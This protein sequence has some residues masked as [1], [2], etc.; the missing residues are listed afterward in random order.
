MNCILTHHIKY[1]SMQ[2]AFYIKN[3]FQT[4][5]CF[6]LL[7]IKSHFVFFIIHFFK[8]CI[9]TLCHCFFKAFMILY[10]IPYCIHL[11]SFQ[12][13]CNKSRHKNNKNIFCYFPYFLCCLYS[14]YFFHIHIKKNNMILIK[15][16]SQI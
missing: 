7:K 5:C 1:Q 11:V 9:H 14:I 8:D 16:F 6:P 15:F 2:I 3:I 10:E 13:I 4:D 12:R